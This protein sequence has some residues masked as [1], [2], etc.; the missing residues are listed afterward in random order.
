MSRAFAENG[1]LSPLL[2]IWLPNLLFGL[3]TIYMYRIMPK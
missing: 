2:A 3:V 1:S